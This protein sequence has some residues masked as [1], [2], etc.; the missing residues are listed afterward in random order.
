MCFDNNTCN[1]NCCSKQNMILH[2]MNTRRWFHSLCCRD[3]W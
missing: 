3:L 2:I 1:N